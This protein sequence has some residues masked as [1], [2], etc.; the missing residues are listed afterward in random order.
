[1]IQRDDADTEYRTLHMAELRLA[2]ES[3]VREHFLSKRVLEDPSLL[4]TW[5]CLSGQFYRYTMVSPRNHID[6]MDMP[7]KKL[8]DAMIELAWENVTHF[9][10][11]EGCDWDTVDIPFSD[12]SKYHDWLTYPEY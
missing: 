1:M 12:C 11:A 9:V 3:Q 4:I 6:W 7:L 2:V 10:I 8:Y 5:R